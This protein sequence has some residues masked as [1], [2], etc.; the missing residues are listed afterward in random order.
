[1][2][3]VL[4][5][6]TAQWDPDRNKLSQRTW[7]SEDVFWPLLPYVSSICIDNEYL[8]SCC[9]K[10][11]NSC[12]FCCVT[13]EV[14]RYRSLLLITWSCSYRKLHN[15]VNWP[16]FEESCMSTLYL[17]L[18]F[19]YLYYAVLMSHLSVILKLH[20]SHVYIVDLRFLTFNFLQSYR[21]PD[22]LG[23]IAEA[24]TDE[25]PNA[26]DHYRYTLFIVQCANKDIVSSVGLFVPWKWLSEHRSL[27]L[28]WEIVSSSFMLL[29]ISGTSQSFHFS[30]L[31]SFRRAETD[32]S[33]LSERQ[34]SLW[35]VPS[36]PVQPIVRQFGSQVAWG[37][38][39]RF[40][41]SCAGYERERHGLCG[42]V[43]AC[44]WRGCYF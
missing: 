20:Y 29:N 4:K 17:F 39:Q 15:K 11:Q 30:D 33:E 16:W 27:N 34:P 31:L 3:H 6:L 26:G 37:S 35:A 19:F 36:A 22:H 32:L 2:W 43:D 24:D 41:R 42:A 28:T 23:L 8:P 18:W 5:R 25:H 7:W 10:T 12:K 38:Q 13:Y 40:D 21:Q 14:I 44:K 9:I 1:M